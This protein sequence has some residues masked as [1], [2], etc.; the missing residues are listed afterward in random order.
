MP[1]PR[2]AHGLMGSLQ[3]PSVPFSV[4]ARA[5][6]STCTDLEFHAMLIQS[7]LTMD[8]LLCA[9]QCPGPHREMAVPAVHPESNWWSIDKLQCGQVLQGAGHPHF[10]TTEPTCLEGEQGWALLNEFARGLTILRLSKEDVQ[11]Y[12]GRNH[13]RAKQAMSR[14]W[15]VHLQLDFF[16]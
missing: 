14:A 5:S 13:F 7:D 10:P 16:F 11:T 6:M 15:V 1:G 3:T 2:K 4:H 12:W 9:G 8:L